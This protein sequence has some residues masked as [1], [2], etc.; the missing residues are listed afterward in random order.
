MQLCEIKLQMS[1]SHHP[2]TDG[3]SEVM[4]RVVETYLRCYCSFHQNDCDVLLPT[5]EFAHNS[6]RSED[7]GAP[8]PN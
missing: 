7:L 8:R 2:Q 4:N 3:V 5:A 6:A 1:S